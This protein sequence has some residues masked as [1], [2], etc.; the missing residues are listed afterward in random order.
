MENEWEDILIAD[1]KYQANI[2]GEIRN[3]KTKRILKPVINKYG[4]CIYSIN[5]KK[6]KG[7]KLIATTFKPNPN[8]LPQV[9]HKDENKQNN[10]V[11][12]LEWCNNIYNSNYGSRNKRIASKNSIP[13]IQCDGDVIIN[14]FKSIREAG[15]ITGIQ[16][17][18]IKD[19]CKGFRKTAGKYIWK[20]KEV[21]L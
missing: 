12:N 8:N 16:E 11:D 17:T 2:Y 21:K 5:G 15:K 7:H 4:Y 3:K 14:E 10:K 9:N 1:N 18:H 20:Y 13:V 6:I 19:V